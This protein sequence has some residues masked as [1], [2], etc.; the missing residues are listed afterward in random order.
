MELNE[1]LR[2]RMDG[3]GLEWE[4]A[5]ALVRRA[6][7][8]LARENPAGAGSDLTAVVDLLVAAPAP[9]RGH[10]WI[11]VQLLET[12]VG[13]LMAG[14]GSSVGH[15]L[16]ELTGLEVWSRAEGLRLEEAW[17]EAVGPLLTEE[18]L[19]TLVGAAQSLGRVGTLP[20]QPAGGTRMLEAWAQRAQ[21]M[22]ETGSP[23][24]EPVLNALSEVLQAGPW[25]TGLVCQTLC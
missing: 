22:V 24:A 17:R 5:L 13:M 18:L 20:G 16:G 8:E 3:Q 1:D 25:G 9:R 14:H 12:L 15:V 2:T 6:E 11:R 7:V 4:L 23:L 21:V 10:G 19:P